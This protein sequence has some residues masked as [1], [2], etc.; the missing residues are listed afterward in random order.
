MS[1]MS[2]QYPKEFQLDAARL[3]VEQGHSANQ[4]A[5]DLGTS[6]HTVRTW[7]KKFLK[8]GELR[9]NHTS[10]TAAEE[11]KKLRKENSRLKMEMDILKKAA[12][13]FAKETL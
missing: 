13:Y 7:V 2:K 3:V 8:S 6:D 4:V 11:L 1:N 12:A 5:K 9:E 10:L